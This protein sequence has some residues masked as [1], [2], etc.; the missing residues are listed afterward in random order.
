MRQELFTASRGDGAQLDGKRIRVS[1]QTTLEGALI[2][3]GFPYR[4]NA[5]WTDSYM[6]MLKRGH[7]AGSRHPPPGRGRA[8]SGLRCGR[9]ARWVLGNRSQHLGYGGWHLLITEAGGR[10]GTLTGGE[11]RQSGN[12]LAGTPKVFEA[13]IECLGPHVPPGLRET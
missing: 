3:T 8:R 9:P 4:S 11:Y 13:M 1:R 12:I 2:G 7:G 5:Q 10:V 6:A